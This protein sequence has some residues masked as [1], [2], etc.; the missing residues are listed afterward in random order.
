MIKYSTEKRMAE[1]VFPT[2]ENTLMEGF[3]QNT[4]KIN[5]DVYYIGASDR[6]L[7]LFENAY[8]LINGVSYNSYLIRDEA[9]V[10]LDTVDY[11][12]SRVFLDNLQFALGDSSFGL[13]YYQ[14]Y[15]TGSLLDV[16]IG[17]KPLPERENH[18]YRDGIQTD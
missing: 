15:G 5:E 8:P 7:A 18:R 1:F 11:S 12:V 3:M 17:F 9:Y 14:P 4:Q 10:L 6:R 2:E 13:H 16:G